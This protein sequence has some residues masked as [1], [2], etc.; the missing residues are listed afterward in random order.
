M[1]P[2][3]SAGGWGGT[4]G[5]IGRVRGSVGRSPSFKKVKTVVFEETG[6]GGGSEHGAFEVRS[7]E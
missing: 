1:Y 5:E 2:A 6:K 4:A 3:I 7:L